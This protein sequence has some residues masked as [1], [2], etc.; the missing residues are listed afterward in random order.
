LKIIKYR[1]RTAAIRHFLNRLR[2]F[3]LTNQDN[4]GTIADMGIPPWDLVGPGF[5]AV[6]F[7]FFYCPTSKSKAPTRAA[8]LRTV[9]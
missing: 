5:F 1:K 4:L 8:E 6:E 2:I 7:P 9:I 3:S